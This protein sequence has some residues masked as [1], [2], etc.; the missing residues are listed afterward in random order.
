LKKTE[1]RRRV[2]AAAVLEASSMLGLSWEREEGE[3][4][5]KR[6]DNESASRS[7]MCFGVLNDNVIK[8]MISFVVNGVYIN[9]FIDY[10]P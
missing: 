1:P 4:R 6:R 7:L 10:I 8:G 2:G 9:V 5:E 3:R